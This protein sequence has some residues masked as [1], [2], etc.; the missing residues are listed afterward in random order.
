L[1]KALT[2]AQGISRALFFPHTI[3]RT[4]I[5]H[6]DV[7][8]ANFLLDAHFE[9]KLGDFGLSRDVQV[10]PD[11]DYGNREISRLQSKRPAG[12]ASRR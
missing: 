12:T 9:P 11:R 10:S 2:I 1:Y 6:G 7:K 5:I 4:P 8:S 3:A